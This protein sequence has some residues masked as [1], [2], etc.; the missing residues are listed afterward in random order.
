MLLGADT[1][2]LVYANI[3]MNVTDDAVMHQVRSV[4]ET[5]FTAQFVAR[6]IQSVPEFY[7]YQGLD[8]K[9]AYI[10]NLI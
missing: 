7:I 6:L 10:Q 1:M 9:E 5:Y 4:S 8:Q 3:L 2:C